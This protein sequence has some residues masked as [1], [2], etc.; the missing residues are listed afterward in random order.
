M[1]GKGSY[2]PGGKWIHDRAH[3]IMEEGETQNKYGPKQGKQIAYAIATQQAHKMGTTP[4]KKGG[5]GTRLGRAVAK[6]KFDQPR[7]E[8]KKTAE[9]LTAVQKIAEILKE[10]SLTRTLGRGF[11]AMERHPAL[12]GAIVGG[13]AGGLGGGIVGEKGKKLETAAKMGLLGTGLGAAISPGARKILGDKAGGAIWPVAT[14]L[15]V[16][17]AA[18]GLGMMRGRE[19]KASLAGQDL[20]AD[21]VGKPRFPTADSKT[22]S[23]ELLSKSQRAAEVGPAPTPGKVGRD[24]RGP[25]VKDSS[26]KFGTR[27][28]DLPGFQKKGSAM[29]NLENDPLMQYMRKQAAEA[30]TAMDRSVG[31]TGDE[32]ADRKLQEQEAADKA[33]LKAL[34]SHQPE[35][36]KL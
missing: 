1:P 30:K 28:G 23:N 22:L 24:S 7:R 15:A 21:F 5:Y 8:Y 17:G 29:Q 12:E 19:K 10:A 16:G 27:M 31:K 32:F 33:I 3:R 34:F 4:K 13:L 14:G 20:R 6:A 2:G 25:T 9:D 35:T 11:E 18:K 36:P 26:P